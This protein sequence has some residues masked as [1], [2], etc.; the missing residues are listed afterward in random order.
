MKTALLH[1]PVLNRLLGL[2]CHQ[3]KKGSKRSHWDGQGQARYQRKGGRENQITSMP[4]QFN[5]FWETT[6]QHWVRCLESVKVKGFRHPRHFFKLEL[7]QHLDTKLLQKLTWAPL[8]NQL[9]LPWWPTS[10]AWLRGAKVQ[11][12]LQQDPETNLSP[13]KRGWHIER[14]LT[15]V[16]VKFQGGTSHTDV[17]P[18]HL[19]ASDQGKHIWK[20]FNIICLFLVLRIALNTTY[21]KS[22]NHRI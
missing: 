12:L 15:L 11:L 7:W 16:T 5:H 3:G 18:S 9:T 17:L 1:P 22:Q 10:Q 20:G 13:K 2:F 14:G 21:S 8:V 6:S 4:L 19:W